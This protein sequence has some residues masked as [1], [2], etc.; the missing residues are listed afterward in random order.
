M[1]SIAFIP[2]INF[3]AGAAIGASSILLI[4]PS[5]A[6]DKDHQRSKVTCVEE[7]LDNKKSNENN[8]QNVENRLQRDSGIEFK[9][10]GDS[11]AFRRP[12]GIVVAIMVN[13][14]EV[15]LTQTAFEIAE[16]FT[17]EI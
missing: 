13:M 4:V 14:Q 9:D 5:S 11:M 7:M 10:T 1:N 16:N 2:G 12:Q 17:F 3:L 8:S 6:Q 15:G